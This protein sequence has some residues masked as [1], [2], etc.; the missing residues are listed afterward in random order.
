MTCTTK[1][2]ELPVPKLQTD[3]GFCKFEQTINIGGIEKVIKYDIP[4]LKTRTCNYKISLE[5]CYPDLPEVANQILGQAI[6]AGAKIA[7][8]AIIT[9]PKPTAE[10][11]IDAFNA[12]FNSYLNKHRDEIRDQL[13]NVTTHGNLETECSPWQNV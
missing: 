1:I 11:A 10:I 4:C 13:T 8:V 2:I 3:L 9:A 12:E 5:I 7:V 6:A